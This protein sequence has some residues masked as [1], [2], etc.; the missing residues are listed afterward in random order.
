MGGGPY[1][2][3]AGEFTDDTSTAL[4][5]SESLI[6]KKG[7]SGSD[8]LNR[9]YDW[10]TTGH[11]GSN[12]VCFDIG[13]G[14]RKAVLA[15]K[16]SGVAYPDV[17]GETRAGNGSLMR[18]VPIV[19]AY[20]NQSPEVLL[21]MAVLSSRTTHT[22]Q[23]CLD[24]CQ[25]YAS[26]ISGALLGKTK[27]ELL[28]P[29]FF[30]SF[31]SGAAVRTSFCPEILSIVEGS[32]KVKQPPE[33][34]GGGYVVHALEAALWAFFRSET[35]EEGVLKVANLGHDA[36][37]TAAIYGQLAGAY[38][39]EEAI[40]S[41][42]R[43]RLAFNSFVLA[44]SDELFSLS[45]QKAF[46]TTPDAD[47]PTSSKLSSSADYNRIHTCLCILETLYADIKRR[48]EPG[49]K[50]FSSMD[51]LDAAVAE[52]T[53]AYQQKAPDCPA[54]EELL[55]K[56]FIDRIIKTQRAK[57]QLK[58]NKPKIALPFG[59]LPAKAESS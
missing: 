17:E 53:K 3:V 14:T 55:Q 52:F 2:L 1:S 45:Q 33:I 31:A 8:Q 58:L 56:E 15:Y 37:T 10:Y 48:L 6:D 12:N 36:D 16:D 25:F 18:L 24:A 7:F 27:E 44:I 11:L 20:Y 23:S 47:F 42:W 22:A 19:L 49:P 43:E 9:Y 26:L 46:H 54:K 28:E 38:Y 41:A 32:Y 13:I 5:L 4:L 59:K 30:D 50:M 57:L 39:G 35:Y 51:Q 34:I 40:P 21:N 29:G